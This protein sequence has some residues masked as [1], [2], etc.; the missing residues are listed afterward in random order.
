MAET[1][2]RGRGT[3]SEPV[4]SRRRTAEAPEP[5]TTTG[6]TFFDE[7]TFE[8]SHSWEEQN[9][10]RLSKEELEAIKEIRIAQGTYGKRMDFKMRNGKTRGCNLSAYCED[11]PVGTRIRPSSVRLTELYDEMED[12]TIWRATGEA[13]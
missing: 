1:T 11:F 9:E 12:R 2:R 13:L 7:A 3:S 6:A 10:V 4:S 5:E 8:F